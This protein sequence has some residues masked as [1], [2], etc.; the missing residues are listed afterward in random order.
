MDLVF[1]LDSS[2]SIGSVDYQKVREFTNEI[3]DN[4]QIGVQHT[5]V[6]VLTFSE[7]AQVQIRLDDT[8]NKEEL[9]EKVSAV[10]YFGYRTAT[11]DALR[12]ANTDMFST[13]GG[14]RQG[15][16]QVLI[17]LTDG[18]C[19][20]CTESVA[21]AVAPLKARGVNIYTIGVTNGINNTELAMIASQPQSLH[22][23]NV[24]N[25]D[26]LKNLVINLQTRSCD[27]M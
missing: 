11:D 1:A 6:G 7:D 2:G 20:V 10:K 18:K 5:H 16:P 4:F 27:G 9:K 17:V 25:F 15:V 13:R 8:F 3:I 21:T 22:M 19:T 12:V 24:D 23:F 26:Q 14:A